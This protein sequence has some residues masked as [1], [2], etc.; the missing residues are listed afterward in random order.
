[1]FQSYKYIEYNPKTDELIYKIIDDEF[2][3]IVGVRV[4]YGAGAGVAVGVIKVYSKRG[5]D[6][7]K[8]GRNLALLNIY[9]TTNYLYYTLE[10]VCKRQDYYIKK[11]K[12]VENWEQYKEAR[13]KHLQLF[14]M[15][16]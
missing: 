5:C 6:I 7:N 15:L 13:D 10:E 9:I 14:E 2:E 16:S 8:I 3:E 4:G 12:Y 1:M 11:Y